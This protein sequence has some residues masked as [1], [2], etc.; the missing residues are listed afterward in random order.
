[1]LSV[2]DDAQNATTTAV[3]PTQARYVRLRITEGRYPTSPG[4]DTQLAEFAVYSA[5]A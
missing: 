1:M 4:H 3:T 5:G 2:T